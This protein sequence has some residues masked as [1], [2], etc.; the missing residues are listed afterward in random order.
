MH[1]ENATYRF[2]PTACTT[3]QVMALLHSIH[4]GPRTIWIALAGQT[5]NDERGILGGDTGLSRAG[6]VYSRAVCEFIARRERSQ[7]LREKG[8]AFSREIA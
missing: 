6:I 4:L 8:Y 5:I 3:S 2:E 7:Q 1:V